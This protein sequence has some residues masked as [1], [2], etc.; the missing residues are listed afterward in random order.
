MQN[1]RRFSSSVGSG[2]DQ[3]CARHQ[4]RSD[5]EGEGK[6]ASSKATV[7]AGVDF[8]FGSIVEKNTVRHGTLRLAG[9]IRLYMGPGLESGA[10]FTQY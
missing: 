1:Q 7:V 4:E 6:L 5:N 3:G 8:T 9:R 2:A 10:V